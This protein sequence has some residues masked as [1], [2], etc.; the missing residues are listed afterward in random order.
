MLES[1]LAHDD[2]DESELD[3][4]DASPGYSGEYLVY[5]RDSS[6]G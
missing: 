2:G 1:L 6:L 3:D 4:L 5:R